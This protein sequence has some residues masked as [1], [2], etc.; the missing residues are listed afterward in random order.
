MAES[1]IAS[2]D[3]QVFSLA[4]AVGCE[5]LD[6]ASRVFSL[7]LH[8]DPS[9]SASSEHA[10]YMDLLCDIFSSHTDHLLSTGWEPHA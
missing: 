10:S 1:A 2:P 6:S 7:V 4:S 9:C 8:T 3:S 5:E